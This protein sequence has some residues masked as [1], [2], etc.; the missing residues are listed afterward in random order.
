M[1]QTGTAGALFEDRRIVGRSQELIDGRS[2]LDHGL[3]E[4]EAPASRFEHTQLQH[5]A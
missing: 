2:S 5:R 1:F 3:R 4:S